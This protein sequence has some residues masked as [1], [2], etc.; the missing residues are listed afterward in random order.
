[1]G[2]VKGEEKWRWDGIS[3]PE[4]CLGEGKGSHTRTGKL[5]NH[6]EGRGSKGSGAMLPLSTWT[7]RNLLRSQARS[8]AHLGPLQPFRSSGSGREG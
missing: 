4:G 7:P 5:G 6:W 2:R 1:M 8:S 3:A